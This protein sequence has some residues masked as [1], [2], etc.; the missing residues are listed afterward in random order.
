MKYMVNDEVMS[1]GL[2]ICKDLF[3]KAMGNFEILMELL[4]EKFNFKGV[5]HP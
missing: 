5:Q 3:T 1:H 2:M 4:Y